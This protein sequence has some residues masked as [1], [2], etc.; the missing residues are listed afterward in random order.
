MDTKRA[1]PVFRS[2]LL[3]ALAAVFASCGGTPVESTRSLPAGAG[4]PDAAP[5]LAGTARNIV[6][7]RAGERRLVFE[8]PSQV[9]PECIGGHKGFGAAAG[10]DRLHLNAFVTAPGIYQCDDAGPFIF[11]E[12]RGGDATGDYEISATRPSGGSCQLVVEAVHPRMRA[13]FTARLNR[14]SGE[15][16]DEVLLAD[17]ELDIAMDSAGCP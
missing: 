11:I 7:V 8:G 16:A 1:L 3:T 10:G 9:V 12:W 2:T 6:R 4:S 14:A 13:R 15:G 5:D 17:G